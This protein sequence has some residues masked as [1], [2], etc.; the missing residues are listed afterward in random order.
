VRVQWAELPLTARLVVTWVPAAIV[1][2]LVALNPAAGVAAAVLVLGA[3]AATVTYVKNRTD[4]HNAAID[5]G[6][7]QVPDDPHLV[8]V[9]PSA[10]D[11]ATGGRLAELGYA[12]GDIGQVKRFDGGWIAKRRNV[13]DIAVVIGDDGGV[14]YFDPRWVP[15]VHAANEYLAGRGLERP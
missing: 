13:R 4:R 14:A 10:L 3:A 11:G 2:L 9:D 15:D 5:R 6:E 7:L 12:P 1:V 8:R